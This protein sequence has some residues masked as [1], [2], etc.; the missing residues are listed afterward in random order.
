MGKVQCNDSFLK[1]Y[2]GYPIAYHHF[3]IRL[4]DIINE[5]STWQLL[6]DIVQNS[7][8]E[9]DPVDIDAAMYSEILATNS[10]YSENE[11]LRHLKA[12]LNWLESEALQHCDKNPYTDLVTPENTFHR[13]VRVVSK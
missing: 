7:D 2:P 4:K 9:V 12:V 11:E 13:S 1:P 5:S 10:I 8:T 6:C 3:R